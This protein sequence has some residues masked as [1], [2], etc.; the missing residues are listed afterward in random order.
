MMTGDGGDM[1]TADGGSA[2]EPVAFMAGVDSLIDDGRTVPLTDDGMTVITRTDSGWNMTV[3]GT[4]VTFADSDRGA[5]PS[6]SPGTYF[7]DLGADQT[8][9]FWSLEDVDFYGSPAPQFDYLNVYGFSHSDLT[10]GADVSSSYTIDDYVRTEVIHIVHGTPTSM[11]PVDGT[12]TYGGRVWAAERS[13]DMA[14]LGLGRNL[15]RGDFSM[16][17][18]FGASGVEVS[19]EFSNLKQSVLGGNY[20]S[21]PDTIPFETTVEGNQL[22]IT[23]LNISSGTFAGYED[24][25]LRAAFF[26]PAAAEVGG[27]FEGENPAANMLLHGWFGGT[28]EE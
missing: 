2:S 19:G 15:Y 3:N 14:T 27:V 18:A 9:I 8:A 10:P 26:G 6:L 12:A 16:S 22:S 1:M 21:I 7:K 25:G 11:M 20:T 24:I 4:S 23:G 5:H 17:A 13:S 28:K